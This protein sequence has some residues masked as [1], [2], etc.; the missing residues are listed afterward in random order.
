M[1]FE[2]EEELPTLVPISRKKKIDS[3]QPPET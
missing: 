3:S 2:E 1:Y